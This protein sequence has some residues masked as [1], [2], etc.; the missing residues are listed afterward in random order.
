MSAIGTRARRLLESPWV[1]NVFRIIAIVSL[2]IGLSVGAR[3]YR[4]TNCLTAYNE[5]TNKASAQ[6]AEAA[7]SDREALDAMIKAIADARYL[8]PGEAGKAVSDA[9]DNYL[10]AR[11]AGDKQRQSNPLPGPPSQTCG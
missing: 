1:N 4:L 8:P 2:L 7:T 11:A 6:R 5:A 3:Q 9:L 10:A